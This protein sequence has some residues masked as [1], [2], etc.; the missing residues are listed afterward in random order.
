MAIDKWVFGSVLREQLVAAHRGYR[1]I[2][3]ENTMSAFEA[4]IGKCDFVELDVGF[5]RDGVAIIIHDDTLERTSDVKLQ[6]NFTPP[7]NVVDYSYKE[8]LELDFSSWFI[9]QD[10]F[11]TIQ[12]KLVTKRELE[13]LPIQRIPTL[14]EALL[15]FK[16]HNMPVNVE[17]KDLKKTDFDDTATE[18]VISI[19]QEL[20][21]EDMILLSSFNHSYIAKAHKIAPMITCAA[22][23]EKAHHGNLIEYLKKLKVQCYHSEISITD[24]KLVSSL[25]NAGIIVNVF[26]ANKPEDKTRLYDY[27][28]K[29]IFT[30]FL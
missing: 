24:A 27:G 19:I 5:S 11:Q 30:D 9:E 22:L 8:L 7:Y 23:Q 1:A 12:N 17:I 18:H 16:Q 13:S 21:M 26:T 14:Q 15:F 6:S 28:V 29:S 4:C 25:N 2:R 20:D 3:A 10:P